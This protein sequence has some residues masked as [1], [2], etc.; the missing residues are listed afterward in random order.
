VDESDVRA[1]AGEFANI[2]AGRL[3]NRLIEAGMQTQ[4]QL[5][6]TWTG[7]TSDG[8]PASDVATLTFNSTR[9]PASFGLLLCVGCDGK[10]QVPG[11]A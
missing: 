7:L 1:T 10:V 8:F 9:P 2:I 11:A 4:M 5:P 6:T 3:R